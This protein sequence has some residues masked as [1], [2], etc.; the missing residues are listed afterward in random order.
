[1]RTSSTRNP[2]AKPF[3]ADPLSFDHFDGHHEKT[4][5]SRSPRNFIVA[6]L[7]P[8]LRSTV[9]GVTARLHCLIFL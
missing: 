7:A 8:T 2:F 6:N 4:P 9:E 1:M 3:P 5:M